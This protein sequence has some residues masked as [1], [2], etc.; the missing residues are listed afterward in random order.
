MR[1]SGGGRVDP[2]FSKVGC[3]KIAIKLLIATKAEKLKPAAGAN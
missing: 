1:V 2:S 3:L